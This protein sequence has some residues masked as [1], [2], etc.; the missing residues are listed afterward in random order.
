MGSW[1]SIEPEEYQDKL[2]QRSFSSYEM[3]AAS[4]YSS[5]V[6]SNGFSIKPKLS[7]ETLLS[8]N[9]YNFEYNRYSNLNITLGLGFIL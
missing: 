3:G 7:Y 1:T 2:S 9:K 4:L 8:V 6:S 5:F